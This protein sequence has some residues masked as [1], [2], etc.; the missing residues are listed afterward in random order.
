MASIGNPNGLRVVTGGQA[1]SLDVQYVLIKCYNSAFT[2]TPTITF[3]TDN[4]EFISNPNDGLAQIIATVQ[5]FA[6][7]YYVGWPEANSGGED[8]LTRVVVA[9]NPNSARG[10]DSSNTVFPTAT[11]RWSDLE[12]A[13]NVWSG[14]GAEAWFAMPGIGW[15]WSYDN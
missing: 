5:D 1:G 15:S 10:L 4:Y 6:E 8:Y 13:L 3:P 9:I 14:G 2:L 12:D 11:G 7:I